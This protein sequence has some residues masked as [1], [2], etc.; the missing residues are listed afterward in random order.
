MK[1]F[2]LLASLLVLAG[3]AGGPRYDTS[4]PSANHDSRV[5]FVIVHYTSASLARSLQLLTHGEVSSHYLIGDDKSAT[6]YKLMDENQRAWHAGESQWQG[7][8]WLN[9]SSI[10]IEIVN[11]GFKDTPTGRLWFP[12]SE[13]QIQSLIVLLKDISQ[14]QGISPR[15]IIGHSDIAPLRKLDPGPLFPW[16]RLA[17][18]G[19]GVWP[20]EQA[21]AR[22][23]VQFNAELP[24]I[25]W[26]QEQLARVGYDTPQT[27][28]LD[29][30]TRHVLAAFQM[31]FR[32]SRFDGLPDAQTAALLLVLNQTK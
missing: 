6:I 16:K 24:S 2:A 10:G 30:A 15:H 1:F 28:E 18:E 14:R 26:F 19:L 4:H 25:S 13:A 8:T 21:V 32:P 27:G 22:Q 31:H 23:Q 5:Q 12:Y 17:A 11:P 7:R 20:N 29:V 9:S 3:C